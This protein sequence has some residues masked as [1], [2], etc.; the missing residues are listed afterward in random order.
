MQKNQKKKIETENSKRQ[1]ARNGRYGKIS[2]YQKL[3][4]TK[5]K[6]IK[7]QATADCKRSNVKDGRQGKAEKYEKLENTIC[8]KLEK[9][10][11]S[12]W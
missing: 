12:G 1:V 8:K 9:K 6:N 11:D 2:K 4:G 7:K 3:G 5:C 10:K